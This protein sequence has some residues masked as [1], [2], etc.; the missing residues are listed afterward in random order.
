MVHANARLTHHGRML[1]V[2]RIITD[3]R[4]VAHVAAELGVSRQ[5]AHRWL[6]RFRAEGVVGLADRSSRPHRCP[7]RTPVA[8]EA[9]VIAL[10]RTERRGQ[11]WIAAELGV[12]ARTVSAILRRH[13]MPYLRQ[14]DPLTGAIIRA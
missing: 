2:E 7:R 6:R 8:I 14:C 13:Q 9:A 3:Q 5:C 10:R 4:P 12:S 11:D 1:L